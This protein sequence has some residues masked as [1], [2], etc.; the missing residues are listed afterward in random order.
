MPHIKI[1]KIYIADALKK[2]YFLQDAFII[3]FHQN[4][5]HPAVP[6]PNSIRNKQILEMQC[7]SSLL[8][9]FNMSW[10]HVNEDSHFP[11]QNI[12]FGVFSTSSTKPRVGSAIGDFVLDLSGLYNAGLF[13]DLGFASNVF[14]ES[15][16]NSFIALDQSTWMATRGRIIS[17]LAADSNADKRLESNLDLRNTV[18]IPVKN[19]T[20]HLPATIGDY[21]DFYSSR[22]HAT[23][24]GIMFRGVDNAL[25]PNWLHLPVGYHGRSSSIVIS[26][27]DV[28][29]PSGQLQADKADPSK[30]SIFSSCKL[31]DF[32]LEMAFFVGGAGNPQGKPISIAEAE[33]SIFGVVLLNDWSARDIQAWEYV[34]LGPFTAKNFASSISPWIVT[35]DALDS[36]RCSTSAGP[37]QDNPTPLPYLVD[38]DYARSTYDV[39]LEVSYLAVARLCCVLTIV[40]GLACSCRRGGGGCV[41]DKRVEPEVHVLEHEA[42]AR[43]PQV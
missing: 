38:P 41:C 39:R 32:E 14:E 21:T 11:I 13:S 40:V 22:E 29:R 12:P 33:Q 24:V 19:V 9:T 25:Q 28:V 2:Y 20:M 23:N 1:L 6:V 4:K 42:A 10:I 3:N 15:T 31:L 16:L 37:V 8:V 30:G 18:L 7:L 34:P 36:F 43:A 17:L 5:F 35:L 27:T 26:G